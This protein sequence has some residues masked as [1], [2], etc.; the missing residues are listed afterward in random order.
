M[1]FQC[2]VEFPYRCQ[3][4]IV[5]RLA[6]FQCHRLLVLE[7]E[8]ILFRPVFVLHKDMRRVK[9]VAHHAPFLPALL[10]KTY[11]LCHRRLVV[12]VRQQVVLVRRAVDTHI[13]TRAAQAVGLTRILAEQAQILPRAENHTLTLRQQSHRRLVGRKSVPT[14]N[15]HQGCHLHDY[16]ACRRETALLLH[17]D[18]HIRLTALAR[19]YAMP[20]PVGHIL[21]ILVVQRPKPRLYYL[22]FRIAHR[23]GC[24]VL[25]QTRIGLHHRLARKVVALYLVGQQHRARHLLHMP[26]RVAQRLAYQF[27]TLRLA[28]CPAYRVFRRRIQYHLHGQTVVIGRLGAFLALIKQLRVPTVQYPHIHRLA[29]STALH[30]IRHRVVECRRT[31]L[32]RRRDKTHFP[33]PLPHCARRD[34]LP[35]RLALFLLGH[36]CRALRIVHLRYLLAVEVPM[37]RYQRYQQVLLLARMNLHRIRVHS[38]VVLVHKALQT[39][40]LVCLHLLPQLPRVRRQVARIVQP[41]KALYALQHLLPVQ[42]HT[43][44]LLRLLPTH[45]RRQHYRIRIIRLP[46]GLLMRVRQVST[47]IRRVFIKVTARRRIVLDIL[48]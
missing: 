31:V 26:F 3:F 38:L 2:F 25:R 21:A 14:V 15:A 47:L 30:L 48:L 8:H 5:A 33:L 42:T 24:Y 43:T 39:L 35:L 12:G 46:H 22:R 1:L 4:L 13:D 9:R 11:R 16:L 19:R 45:Y 29:R 41:V 17:R 27:R 32:A 36:S 18:V 37:L 7:R 40:L 44:L 20:G 23:S 34:G 10:A 28:H 6:V